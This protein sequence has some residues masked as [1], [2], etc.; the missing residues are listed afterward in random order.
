MTID[1]QTEKRKIQLFKKTV[2][3]YG[4]QAGVKIQRVVGSHVLRILKPVIQARM[5]E[6]EAGRDPDRVDARRFVRDDSDLLTRT[7]LSMDRHFS[8]CT[9]KQVD[10]L[11]SATAIAEIQWEHGTKSSGALLLAWQIDRD[12]L[13]P[14]CVGALTCCRLYER[15][16]LGTSDNIIK[17]EDFATL[18]PYFRQPSVLFIDGLCSTSPGAGSALVANAI[19]WGLT[20]GHNAVIAQSF[21]NKPLKN[22]KKPASMRMLT[23]LG[24]K[25]LIE[26]GKFKVKHHHGAWMRMTLKPLHFN[27]MMQAGLRVCAR[28][29]FTD[30]TQHTLIDQCP[31]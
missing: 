19:K 1:E 17:A 4:V 28:R 12:T 14:K 18:T 2:E 15:D 24:F 22:G 16:D 3:F 20:K 7:V 26:D 31:A 30:A 23:K 13:R 5:A 21:S 8:E 27:P 6:A 10:L 9:G 11:S 29:G 25:T